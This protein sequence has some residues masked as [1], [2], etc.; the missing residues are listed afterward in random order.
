MEKYGYRNI[1]S[2]KEFEK[3]SDNN[4]KFAP[5]THEM[6]NITHYDFVDWGKQGHWGMPGQTNY[7]VKE[8]DSLLTASDN[9]SKEIIKERKPKGY[10]AW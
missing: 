3:A 4:G 2:R 9:A 6:K 7:S 1:S 5:V 10:V 8:L